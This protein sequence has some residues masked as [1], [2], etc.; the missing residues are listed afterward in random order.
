LVEAEEPVGGSIPLTQALRSEVS[1]E[2][3]A[4][5][6]FIVFV[7][8]CLLFLLLALWLLAEVAH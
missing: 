7:V 4:V 3:V 8:C 1:E 6:D 2:L 5:A